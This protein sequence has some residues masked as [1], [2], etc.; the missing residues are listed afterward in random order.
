MK[1]SIASVYFTIALLS[2]SSIHEALGRRGDLAVNDGY[3]WALEKKHHPVELQVNKDKDTTRRRLPPVKESDDRSNGEADSEGGT[4]SNVMAHKKG[5]TLSPFKTEGI[6]GLAKKNTND[7]PVAFTPP[8]LMPTSFANDSK[9]L[10]GS[11]IGF[12]IGGRVAKSSTLPIDNKAAV[13]ASPTNRPAPVSEKENKNDAKV[14]T[15]ENQESLSMT[16]APGVISSPIRFIT[17]A[18]KGSETNVNKEAPWMELNS[19]P[20]ST[21]SRSIK[22]KG[23]TLGSMAVLKDIMAPQTTLAPMKG[24]VIFNR[25][26]PKD[27][28]ANVQESESLLVQASLPT[29]SPTNIPKKGSV[30]LTK[31][32]PKKVTT[33]EDTN[34]D[35]ITTKIPGAAPKK[36]GEIHMI[37]TH[38]V[39]H[40]T[41][42][43]SSCPPSRYNSPIT[44]KVASN[45]RIPQSV[46]ARQH[47]AKMQSKRVKSKLAAYGCLPNTY[48]KATASRSSKRAARL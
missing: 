47:R 24:S 10:K 27:T 15:K 45:C 18:P 7:S 48:S 11:A 26:G 20:T 22:K 3:I 14:G 38:K 9:N 4:E 36:K 32:D 41:F 29:L 34:Q 5:S 19:V 35:F 12:N 44:P 30:T 25:L 39:S 31:I 2:L 28:D 17:R 6:L 8:S 13:V 42:A 33:K 37:G 46:C 21:P 40:T 43:T 1:T 23:E 16:S